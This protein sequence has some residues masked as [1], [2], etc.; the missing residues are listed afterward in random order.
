ML[1]GR[2][3]QSWFRYYEDWNIYQ[4]FLE[5]YKMYDWRAKKRVEEFFAEI[6]EEDVGRLTFIEKL[7]A[8]NIKCANGQ[9]ASF[10]A[11]KP[12]KRMGEKIRDRAEKELAQELAAPLPIEDMR[13]LLY[14]KE[15]A[16][17][18]DIWD[19]EKER[20][21][22]MSYSYPKSKTTKITM[23]AYIQ[24]QVIQKIQAEKSMGRR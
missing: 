23:Y 19:A 10:Y 14:E 4:E 8:V 2:A 9:V 3:Y 16:V 6:K 12:I 13:K 11:R 1:R 5:E 18:K 15:E 7:S 17:F 22:N 24:I 21:N 20:F